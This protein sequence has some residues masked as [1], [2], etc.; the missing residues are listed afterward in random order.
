MET[1]KERTIKVVIAEADSRLLESHVQTL[2]A[3]GFE[4]FPMPNGASAV[5]KFIEIAPDVAVFD[6]RSETK[7]GLGAA[8]EILRLRPASRIILLVDDL[9]CASEAEKIE[10][11]LI[12][13]T[14][15]TG[16]K[17]AH[18]VKVLANLKPAQ[19]IKA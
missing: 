8:A 7:E 11:D 4:V 1:K 2:R 5:S 13:R 14:G 15:L 17:L 9:A 3:R 10:V 12:L 18:A 16:D 6:L 19:R